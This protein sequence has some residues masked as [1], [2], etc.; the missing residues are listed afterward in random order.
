MCDKSTECSS[1]KCDESQAH[2]ELEAKVNSLQERLAKVEAKVEAMRQEF[3]TGLGDIKNLIRNIYEE[4]AAWSKWIRE[5][6]SLSSI[7]KWLGRLII[8]VTLAAIGLS[9]SRNIRILVFGD[10]A[11]TE[12]AK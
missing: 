2:K 1:I 6:V 4:K 5:S 7:G 9:N 11:Q 10:A 12:V 3:S 8:I